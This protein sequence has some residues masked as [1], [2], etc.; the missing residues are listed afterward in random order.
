MKS[1]LTRTV[2]IFGAC[3]LLAALALTG[4]ARQRQT[5]ERVQR[6]VEQEP[7]ERLPAPAVSA[8]QLEVE[9]LP[10]RELVARADLFRPP[11]ACAG[12]KPVVETH[13]ASDNF[14]PPGSPVSLSPELTAFV[15]GKPTK[16]YDN[17][18]LNSWF[19]DSFRLRNCRVCHAVLQVRV[20]HYNLDSFG[21]DAVIVGLAPYNNPNT[22]F[23]NAG[24]VPGPQLKTYVLPTNALNQYI[25]QDNPLPTYLDVRVQDDHDVDFARLIVWYY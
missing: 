22:I 3:A 21:N 24:L 9:E 18:A 25:V 6:P 20:R 23:V 13:D 11:R 12:L 10:E 4:P 8:E 1:A 17:P 15:A 19:A 7:V 14:S 5:T 16:G 2:S